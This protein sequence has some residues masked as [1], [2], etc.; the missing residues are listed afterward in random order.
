MALALV[1]PFDHLDHAFD[2]L[3]HAFDL[4]HQAFD[5]LAQTFDL[6]DHCCVLDHLNLAGHS[7]PVLT[8]HPLIL[9]ETHVHLDLVFPE[10]LV[11]PIYSE[12]QE[13]GQEVCM[14]LSLLGP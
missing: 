8:P 10:I 12:I 4:L 14:T 5:L 6:L 1:W 2:L 13:T 3:D 9:P 7:Y 11:Q